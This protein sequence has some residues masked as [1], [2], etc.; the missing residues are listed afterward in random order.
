M[1]EKRMTTNL[2]DRVRWLLA[3]KNLSQSRLAKIAGVKQPSVFGWICGKTQTINFVAALRISQAL[4]VSLKWL[5]E[6]VGDP[7]P[8]PSEARPGDLVKEY[9]PGEDQ[10]PAG[11]IAVPEYR[12]T[13]AAN[14]APGDE[15]TWEE[16][17]DSTPHWMPESFFKK[18]GVRPERCRFGRVDGDSME[19]T[20]CDGDK[21]L[22]AEETDP[23]PGCVRIRDGAIYAVGIEG[24]LK[25]K[26]LRRIQ[27]GIEVVSDNPVYKVMTYTGEAA[28]RLR[29][30]GRVLHVSREL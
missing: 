24:D 23:R 13:L 30:F 21:V 29:V 16:I 11:M 1:A 2:S 22:W 7:L 25:V 18:K 20:L 26:R 19:P 3:E 17:N 6:G 4:G 28:D 9:F 27:D 8:A 14:T 10:P 5:A 15:P 12:L